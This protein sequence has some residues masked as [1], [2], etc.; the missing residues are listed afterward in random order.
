MTDV[1]KF[2]MSNGIVEEAAYPYSNGLSP[3]GCISQE[4]TIPVKVSGY[5]ELKNVS[6]DE[7]QRAVSTIGPISI[8]IDARWQ[9]LQFYETG[10][11]FEPLCDSHELNHA[12]LGKKFLCFLELGGK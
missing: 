7:L 10:L 11:Y 12:V 3:E 8:A 9:S 6:E 5:I 2:S 1:F 4:N